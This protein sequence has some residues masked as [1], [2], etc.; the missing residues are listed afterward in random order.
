M[1]EFFSLR[2]S[3]TFEGSLFRL[4]VPSLRPLVLLTIAK[5]KMVAEQWRTDTDMGKR[6]FREK[7]LSQWQFFR[8]KSHVN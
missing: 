1:K 7:M 4:N 2:C 6:K 8:Y 5:T 3:S